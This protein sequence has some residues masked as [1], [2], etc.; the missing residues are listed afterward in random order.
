MIP[1]YD[2][3]TDEEPDVEDIDVDSKVDID[4]EYIHTDRTFTGQSL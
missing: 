1:V 2:D 3:D 4:N